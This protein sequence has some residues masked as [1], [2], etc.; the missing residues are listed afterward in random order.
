VSAKIGQKPRDRS[1]LNCAV[2]TTTTRNKIKKMLRRPFLQEMSPYT[3]REKIFVDIA[4]YV[5]HFCHGFESDIY[6]VASE[7]KSII[8]NKIQSHGICH[9]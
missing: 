9:M 8:K 4:E 7:F 6:A 5:E 2:D 1:G 3:T